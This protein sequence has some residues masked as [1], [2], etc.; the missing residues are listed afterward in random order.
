MTAN[1]KRNAGAALIIVLS[2]IVLVTAVVIAFFARTTTDRQLARSSFANTAADVL[3]R[4]A[5]EVVVGDFKQEITNGGVP[6][7]STIVPQRS[8]DSPDVS[9][10][11]RRS[12]RNDSLALPAIASRASA[13]N[14]T[15]DAS[16]NGRTILT[17]RWNK[18]YL[19]PRLN[20]G[21]APIDSTPIAG[22]VSPDW[23]FVT[24]S[25]PT[26]L[27]VPDSSTIG[28]Y[29]F[30]VYDEGGLLDLNVAGFPSANSTNAAYLSAIGKKGTLA[31]A[32]LTAAELSFA[33]I[34]NLIGWRN[35]ASA[36]PSGDFS[37]TSPFTFGVNPTTFIQ[38]VLETGVATGS[39]RTRDFGVVNTPS[40]YSS[41]NPR[42]DQAVINRTE[43]LELRRILQ[44]NQDSLQYIGTFSRERNRPTWSDA[45]TKLS[46]RFAL[47]RFDYL[48]NP[49]ANS[50]QI[51]QYFGLKYVAASPLTVEHWQYVGSG[52]VL[53]SS[54]MP[55]SGTA[56]DPELFRLL[57]YAL[58]GASIGEILSIGASWI[59]QVDG[60]DETTWIE[61]AS[62]NHALPTQKAFGVDRNASTETDAP[63]R[64]SAVLVLNRPFRNVGELS[65]GYHN[66]STSV[67]FRSAASADAPLL[68]LFTYNSASPR[69]GVVSLN[70]RNPGTLSA[71]LRGATTR[72][73]T[74]AAISPDFMTQVAA[75]TAASSIINDPINGTT[76][77]PILSRT[78]IPRLSVAAVG[79]LG[80][81]EQEQEVIARALAEVTQTRT[82]GLFVDV[83]AQSGRYAPAAT[84]IS[85]FVVEAEKRYWL[86]I[87]IDRFTG[88]VI[89][90]QLEAV[91]E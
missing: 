80:T 76:A 70:T 23:V 91:F 25:G 87:A 33:A 89:D 58:P 90:Q 14:S 81:T 21:S 75:S 68:D 32:D 83:I 10:L 72:D 73:V 24:E 69:S 43:L 86:H 22:F 11:I 18:H 65:Y 64:P 63:P 37:T 1:T 85:Q 62:T 3:A 17:A 9:N 27:N 42:T 35:Y 60:N 7:A 51:Q 56:Q 67:D 13:V 45:A 54:I 16:I 30:A 84:N 88:E 28:R 61:Y 19:I 15:T 5:L 66:A 53:L 50:A 38:Y 55:V 48:L 52:T 49:A 77:K 31:F 6:S 79:S 34:D 26:V 59:D 39:D 71:I 41:T 40:T 29:A 47:N 57:Q 8:G 12:V 74:S 82:W 44:A 78:G 4:S 20:A 36:N 2:F 46:R